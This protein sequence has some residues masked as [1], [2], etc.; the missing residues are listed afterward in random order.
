MNEIEIEEEKTLGRLI[1][2]LD[3]TANPAM[4]GVNGKIINPFEQ[5]DFKLRK[6]DKILVIP[7]FE[8]G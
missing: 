8:G 3:L 2:E 1:D 5:K 7:V 4:L 6:G